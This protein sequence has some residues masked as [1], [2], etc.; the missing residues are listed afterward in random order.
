[1]SNNIDPTRVFTSEEVKTKLSAVIGKTL[2]EADKAELFELYAGKEKVTGIAGQ[3]IE[4]SVLGCKLDSKQE[5][6]ILIDDVLHEIKTTGMVKPKSNDSPYT[7]ECKEPV[8]VTAVSIP[9]IVNEEFEESNFWHKL[10]HMLWVYYFYNSPTTVKLEGYKNF[11][12]LGFQVFEFDLNDQLRLKHDWLLVRDFLIIIH[13]EY[14]TEEDRKKQYPR[15]SHELRNQLLLIDTAPKYPNPPR[16]RLKRSFATI[17]ASKLFAK[18][19]LEKLFKP[20]MEYS[21]IDSKCEQLNK[22]YAGKSFAEIALSLN[23]SLKSEKKSDEKSLTD[24]NFS[25]L[26][27]LKMFET[28]A[29][30]L[31]DIEDFAKI[32]LIAKSLPLTKG[33]IPKESMKLFTPNF[34]EWMS[35][36]NFEDSFIRSYFAEHQFLLIVYKY[37][38][39]DKNNKDPKYIKFVGFKRTY[40]SD[41]FIDTSVWK[42]WHDV[43]DLIQT[44]KLRIIKEYNNDGTPKMNKKSGTQ[45]EAPNF[46]KEKYYDVFMRGSAGN[47]DESSKTLVL[48]DL[49]MLP[50]EV[51]LSKRVSLQL[52]KKTV[53]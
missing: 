13:K 40:L 50:Q 48:N 4:C 44:R 24:K 1:M 52:Y 28:E 45:K 2:L 32:G 39:P 21:D 29:K 42:F 25:E 22:L 36:K 30:R 27:V 23:V 3:I 49:K 18:T 33:G 14:K 53:V 16:F 47:A 5:P 11:P 43:R 34:K 7:Y 10:A 17:I 8:S 31:N 37:T 51:W 26:A 20:I 9:I 38:H 35:E 41:G 15:L 46:P 19:H 6:D 12:I